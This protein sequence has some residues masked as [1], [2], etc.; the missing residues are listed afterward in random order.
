MSRQHPNILYIGGQD[1]GQALLAA[2]QP[3]GWWVYLP[4]DLLEALGMYITYFPDAVVIDTTT[5]PEFASAAYHHLRSVAARPLVVI[6]DDP[7]WD[8]TAAPDEVITC[9]SAAS[10]FDLQL[11]LSGAIHQQMTL[12]LMP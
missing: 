11:I 12:P 5:T 6:T 7:L 8:V 10:P 3:D 2:T 4:A 1:R 9:P